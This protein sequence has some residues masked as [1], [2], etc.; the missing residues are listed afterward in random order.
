M[1]D[2]VARLH[3]AGIFAAYWSEGI[4]NEAEAALIRSGKPAASIKSRFDALRRVFPECLVDDYQALTDAMTCDAGDK[5][6]LAAAVREGVD[7]IVTANIKHFPHESV[8]PY[9]IEVVPPD[10]LLLNALDMH[11][12]RVLSV[13]RQQAAA[14]NRPPMTID[15]VVSALAKHAPN[16]AQTIDTL[17]RAADG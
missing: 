7:Q 15:Q 2:T 17:L 10:D 1:C 6:V 9:G 16:F 13:I 14:L 3:H 12:Q 4:L 5:H 11:P 8:D